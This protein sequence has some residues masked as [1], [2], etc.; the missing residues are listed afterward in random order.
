M[1]WTKMALQKPHITYFLHFNGVKY[2]FLIPFVMFG[3]VK[4]Q[5]MM[6]DIV[7]LELMVPC[8][9]D[10]LQNLYRYFCH[11]MDQNG[12]PKTPQNIFFAF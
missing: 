12:I 11:D 10:S 1:I 2:H 5:F 6:Y 3:K 9:F 8:R 7:K 4:L